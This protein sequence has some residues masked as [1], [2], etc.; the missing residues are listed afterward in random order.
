MNLK[1]NYKFKILLI[2]IT[3]I[4]ILFQ[5]NYSN[6]IIFLIKLNNYIIIIIIII[7]ITILYLNFYIYLNKFNNKIL[8]ENNIIELIWTLI[9]IIIIF[10]II[11]PSIKIIYLNNELKKNIISIKIISNQWFWY[12]EYLNFNNKFNSYIIYK[13]NFNFNLIETDN[14][15]I[16]PFNIPIQLILTSIDVIHSWTI[17]SLNIKI[18]TIPNQLN[19]QIIK[20]NKPGLIY[21][22]CSEICGINHRFIPIKIESINFNNFIKWLK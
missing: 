3:W 17:P 11:I 9:P 16:I 1:F 20:L 5:N 18:D 22:Q 7:I 14:R 12:Y 6:N 2:I 10:I 8:I 19:N 15:I 4:I 13:K 21:G